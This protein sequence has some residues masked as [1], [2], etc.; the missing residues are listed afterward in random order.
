MSK[1]LASVNNLPEA[2]QALTAGVD[3]IDLKQPAAGALGALDINTIKSI[4]KT[5]AGRCP[6]SATIGDLP[7]QADIIFRAVTAMTGTDVDYIKIGF[8]PSNNW[9]TVIKSLQSLTATG[10][11]LIAVLFAD[12]A[13][14]LSVIPQLQQAG[15][16]GI[17]LDTMHKQT[18]S[19]LQVMASAKIEAFVATAKQ[20]GLLTGLAGS[21]RLEDIAKLSPLQADYLGFRG[22]L[23]LQQQRTQA[24]DQHALQMILHA[25]RTHN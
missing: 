1:M 25:V 10:R 16:K 4:V 19:L 17:M 13:P 7:M 23:C 6:V 2:L 18:G 12:T 20:H 14:D 15:F 21:L 5:L 8:F 24:L 9:L 22:A 11:A 3:I